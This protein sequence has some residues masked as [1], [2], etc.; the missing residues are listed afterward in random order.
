MDDIIYLYDRFPFISYIKDVTY[1]EIDNQILQIGIIEK[2]EIN[3]YIKKNKIQIGKFDG[4][5]S[6]CPLLYEPKN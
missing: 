3:K 6:I 5:K 4:K 1:N 2:K